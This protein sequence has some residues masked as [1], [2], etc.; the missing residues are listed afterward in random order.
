MEPVTSPQA[1]GLGVTPSSL[2]QTTWS[3]DSWALDMYVDI[4]SANAS[5]GGYRYLVQAGSCM[6][7]E[8]LIHVFT[9]YTSADTSQTSPRLPGKWSHSRLEHRPLSAV[10]QSPR[11]VSLMSCCAPLSR[12]FFVPC[13][14]SPSVYL[15][16]ASLA[17]AAFFLSFYPQA[18]SI[19]NLSSLP[20]SFGSASA[21]DQDHFTDATAPTAHGHRPSP[22]VHPPSAIR[23]SLSLSRPEPARTSTE[24]TKAIN[25][26]P[27]RHSSQ[28]APTPA[29][30]GAHPIRSSRSFIHSH[31][32]LRSVCLFL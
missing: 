26:T 24:N 1:H 23:H 9:V 18:A 22:T 19:P 32:S 27:T 17:N 8:F 30:S 4:P 16:P 25:H 20:Y 5:I 14:P 29:P 21:L 12:F 10:P 13:L 7:V 2:H 6:Y 31:P 3:S 11:F 15:Y 28:P